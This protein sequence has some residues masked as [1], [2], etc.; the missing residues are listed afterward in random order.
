M[1]DG[2]NDTR[3]HRVAELMHDYQNIQRRIAQFQATPSS[4][5]YHE[6]G[7]TTLRNAHAEARALLSAPFPPE[8][9]HPPTAANEAAKRQLQRMIL[10]GYARRF[11]AQKINHKAAAAMKWI[12][13]RNS[14][15][16]GQKPR[17]C[18]IPQLQQADNTLRNDLAA[19]TDSRIIN[20]FRAADQRYW[21]VDDPTLQQILGWIRTNL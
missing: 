1:A 4:D 21:L 2:F 20:E 15:L 5:E 11:K 14:I 17:N 13:K 6:V 16:Q 8:M 7:Y 12:N 3:A 10:D 19:I 18:H 9:L